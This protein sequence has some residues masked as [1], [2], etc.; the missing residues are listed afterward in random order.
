M[1]VLLPAFFVSGFCA[2]LYQMIWQRVLTFFGGADVYSVTIIVAAFMAGLG[3]GSLAGGLVADRLTPRGCLL[4]FAAAEAAI[5]VFAVVSLPLFYDALYL[6]LGAAGLP[7]LAR[8]GL[9]FATLLV[10]TTAM[11]L[12]LPLLARALTTDLGVSADRIGGLYGW[13]TLGAAAGAP[14]AVFVLVRLIG[15]EGTVYVGAALNLACAVLGFA[16]GQRLPRAAA[17]VPSAAV[18]TSA[19]KGATAPGIGRWIVVYAVSGFVALSLEIVWFRLLGTI[20]KS[21]AFTFAILLSLFLLGVGGGALVGRRLARRTAQPE[22]LFLLLQGC[23]PLY[24]CVSL[25]ALVLALGRIPALDDLWRY[26]GSYEP[27]DLGAALRAVQ[28]F[29]L[30]G[31]GVAP[32]AKDLVA[33]FATLYGLVP[34]FLIVPPTLLMGMSFPVLQ[35]AVQVDIATLGRRV[36]FLQ[37]ANIAGSTAGSVVTGLV[38]LDVL[39]TAA[40]LRLLGAVGLVFLL[41]GSGALT[42]GEKASGRFARMAGVGIAAGALWLSPGAPALW[43]RLHGTT[44]GILFAEDGSGLSVLKE[45]EGRT[46]GTR[47]TVVYVNGIG[48]SQL[49]FGGYHT[50]LGAFPVL[51]HPDPRHVVVIGLGSGDTLFGTGGRAET[52]RMDCIEIIA[53]QLRTLRD[54]DRASGDPGLRGLLRDRRVSF[55]F[56]DGRAMLMRSQDRADVIQADALRPTSA[57]SGNLYSREYFELLKSRLR[58]GGYG[59]TWGP[60]KRTRDTFVSAFPHALVIG[61]ILIGSDR[62]IAFDPAVLK[63]RV[64]DPFTV[65]YYARAGIDVRALLAP[66]FEA[67]PKVYDPSSDRASL[68]DLNTDLY[69]RDEYL[70][71][72]TL[73]GLRRPAARKDQ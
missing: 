61:D 70:V 68:R 30:T 3:V 46:P 49:P 72:E 21:N 45:E 27:L 35:R 19:S 32:W 54:F 36:G 40:T 37:A 33:R 28:R 25:G 56:G 23:I 8:A 62:P 18:A 39:G 43:S 20:L 22:R 55:L 44:A 7:E 64:E 24:A 73:F 10:P 63:Q 17:A 15:F 12:S 16:A 59:V 50:L 52:Q 42:G 2:L 69:P 57:Y 4:A 29:V 6:R 41:W 38:L 47:E 11:G 5:A 60:T 53:P 51:L 65:A 9:L 1:V 13:N 67:H 14:F 66:I 34:L 31:G 71:G 26:L 58:E 48:Q